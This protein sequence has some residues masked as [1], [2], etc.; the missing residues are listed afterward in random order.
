MK[1]ALALLFSLMTAPSITMEVQESRDFLTPE[2]L[3]HCCETLPEELSGAATWVKKH[4]ELFTSF[5]LPNLGEF[6]EV[7]CYG[8]LKSYPKYQKRYGEINL[9]SRRVSWQNYGN[10][11]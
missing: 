1:R 8:Q 4:A 3:L 10:E 11:R 5:R 7:P 2:E 6:T 9:A